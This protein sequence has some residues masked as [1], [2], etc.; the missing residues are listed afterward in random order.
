MLAREA[1]RIELLQ[2][3]NNAGNGRH[4]IVGHGSLKQIKHAN[5]FASFLQLVQV[6]DILQEHEYALITVVEERLLGERILSSTLLSFGLLLVLT[7]NII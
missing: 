5:L 6:G 7:K 3:V 2:E 1:L 4:H